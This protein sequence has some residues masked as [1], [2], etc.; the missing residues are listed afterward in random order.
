VENLYRGHKSYDCPLSTC[1][2]GGVFK[3]WWAVPTLQM[4][5]VEVKL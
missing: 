5:K 2:T 3:G 4:Y 1:L